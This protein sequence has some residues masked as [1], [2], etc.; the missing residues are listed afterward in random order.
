MQWLMPPVCFNIVVVSPLVN[1]ESPCIQTSRVSIIWC[2]A[3]GFVINMKRPKKVGEEKN[4]EFV[5]GL[6]FLPRIT[7]N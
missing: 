4:T 5:L 3:G 1:F 6:D 7:L 2:M